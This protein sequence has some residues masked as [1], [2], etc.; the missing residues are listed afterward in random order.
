KLR[1]HHGK[2]SRCFPGGKRPI[3]PRW[4]LTT[5]EHVTNCRAPHIIL[6]AFLK[7]DLYKRHQWTVGFVSDLLPTG[8]SPQCFRIVCNNPGNIVPS[9]LDGAE[10][11]IPQRAAVFDVSGQLGECVNVASV[12]WFMYAISL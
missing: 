11:L 1:S 6:E 10:L 3:P 4:F 7:G 2:L 12:Q 9:L 8:F 5:L